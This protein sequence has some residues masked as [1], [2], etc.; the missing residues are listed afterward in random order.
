[1]IINYW[2]HWV[3]VKTKGLNCLEQWDHWLSCKSKEMNE[4]AGW[5]L[6]IARWWG[7]NEGSLCILL[8]CV[9]V[10]VCVCV[11]FVYFLLLLFLSS[12]LHSLR[13]LTPLGSNEFANNTLKFIQSNLCPVGNVPLM[14]IR[15]DFH[16]RTQFKDPSHII[17]YGGITPQ[18]QMCQVHQ[19]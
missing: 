1:M 19:A 3:F 8:M 15:R 14:L 17:L 4:S 12:F 11:C 18:A 6:S 16:H 9:C 10:C 2:S 7:Q 5:A 13:K